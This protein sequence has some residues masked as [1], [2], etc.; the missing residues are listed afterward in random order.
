MRNTML[1]ALAL[2][3]CLAILAMGA[4]A[5]AALVEGEYAPDGFTFSGGTGKVK[6]TCPKLTVAGDAVTATLV[7]SSPNYPKLVADGVEY[8]AT[9]DGNTSAFEVPVRVNEDMTVVGTTTAMS[10]PHD[11]EYVIHIYV[12]EGAP[13]DLPEDEDD[14]DGEAATAAAGA[15]DGRDRDMPGLNWQSDMPL[16][17][18]HK[19]AVDYYEGGYKLLTIGDG[20]RYLVVPEG[21]DV[22]AGLD[23]GV[24]IIRQPLNNVYLAATA[25]MALFDA[26][27]GLDVIKLSG[28][29]A[30]GWYIEDAAAAMERG[31]ML[32][33]GKYS[34]PD[35][36]LLM[37]MGCK[38]A[39]ESTMILHT[40]KVQEML[41]QLGITVF[42]EHSSYETHPLGRTEWVKLYAAMLN[43]EEQAEAFFDDQAKIIDEL[44]D[45]PNTEKTVA[46]FYVSTDGSIVVRNVS[47]YVARMIEI[48]GGRY[49]FR[50][51]AQ[52]DSPRS[53]V[54][55]SM[56][57]FYAAAV[58]ADYLIYNAS[59]DAPLNSVADLLG[60]SGLF[61]DFRAVKE[62]N[63]WS[64]DKYLYQ[65]TDIVGELITD[66]NRMLTGETEGMTFIRRLE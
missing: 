31:D 20:N 9:H 13:E 10:M 49:I 65:A 33:A 15:L 11:I 23:G 19:F 55:I 60:K 22:P 48:A 66:L 56:E 58:D 57:D 54:A 39:I 26:V 27:D 63:V 44:K 2:A 29:Q 30:K 43:K 25:A 16:R 1:R 35:Y 8:A 28:T 7:F 40:P 42:I 50:D 41:E 34:E 51:P 3:L 5:E 14:G 62:G 12:G 47:D 17:Y 52:L 21:G 64:T 37:G 4:L 36:E 38:L 6:I 45:F 24:K 59:I 18:A 32:Y 61:A 53:S 46:F